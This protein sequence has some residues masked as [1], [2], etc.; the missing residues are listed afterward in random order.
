M[1]N[2]TL[3]KIAK[4]AMSKKILVIEVTPMEGIEPQNLAKSLGLAP[5]PLNSNTPPKVYRVVGF[6]EQ[7]L[8]CDSAKLIATSLIP[9]PTQKMCEGEKVFSLFIPNLDHVPFVE[10]SWHNSL[11]QKINSKKSSYT[12]Y[13]QIINHRSTVYYD[14]WIEYESRNVGDLHEKVAS[15]VNS[16]E[17]VTTPLEVYKPQI[18][19]VQLRYEYDGEVHKSRTFVHPEYFPV[20]IWE[21]TSE[22][23]G[24]EGFSLLGGIRVD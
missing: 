1:D 5:Y 10:L 18:W 7:I 22:V 2:H 6:D 24:I 12:E 13:N 4:L 16:Y 19:K 23:E 21:N 9:K 17:T 15:V 20:L 11:L 8:E 14:C 3:A